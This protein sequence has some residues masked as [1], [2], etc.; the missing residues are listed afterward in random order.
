M[1]NNFNVDW[2]KPNL[3]KSLLP[4][5]IKEPN[6]TELSGP[7]DLTGSKDRKNILKSGGLQLGAQTVSSLA[8]SLPSLDKTVNSNDALSS[9]IR[10]TVNQTLLQSG[11]PWGMAVGAVNTVMDKLG[12][13]SDASKGLGGAT[14]AAN[15]A[16]SLLLPGSS[17]L[18]KK[19]NELEKNEQVMSSSGY[20]GTS[21]NVD[22]ASQN[23]GAKLLFGANKANSM[24]NKAD[25][26]QTMAAN[27]LKKGE[28]DKIASANPLNAQKVQIQMGG[29][30]NYLT[31]KEGTKLYKRDDAKRIL[32]KVR[33][34][35]VNNTPSDVNSFKNGGTFNV[36]PEGALH[37]NKHHLDKV[38][39]KFEDVT[40][41]G[42]PV[43][44]ESADGSITQHA[45]VEKEE[46]IFRLEVTKKLEDLAKEDTDEAA[47]EAG[48]LLVK[49]ILYNTIDNTNSLL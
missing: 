26:E 13:Y 22:K 40:A 1:P 25:I 17:L 11:N 31:A 41:K 43:I 24:I 38:D 47:I 33:K 5:N 37:K 14:D 21:T 36:I 44:T 7:P 2:L 8:S 39:D 34:K 46:I 35:Q 42:I 20:T 4:V 27:N 49:E 19:T 6:F 28:I 12:L 10:G 9:N 48:K 23:A 18:A 16:S 32:S 29:G 15:F 45:E 3:E 30:Y